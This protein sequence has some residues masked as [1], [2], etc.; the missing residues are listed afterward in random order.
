MNSKFCIDLKEYFNQ[1]TFHVLEKVA[2]CAINS[3]FK[4]YLV[5]GIVRDILLKRPSLDIDILIEGDAL[6]F[7]EFLKNNCTNI[8]VL[9][10]QEDLHT[11]KVIFDN[12]T[13]IDFASTRTEIYPQKGFLPVIEEIGVPIEEDCKRRDFTVNTLL[14]ALHDLHNAQI[15]DLTG[16]LSDLRE[17]TLRILHDKS[18]IDDPSRILRYLKFAVRFGFSADKHTESLLNEYLNNPNEQFP[19][20][21]LKSEFIQTFNLNIPKAAKLFVEQKMYKLFADKLNC[22]GDFAHLSEL[23]SKHIPNSEYI[24]LVWFI[25][26]F[27]AEDLPEMNF[28]TKEKNIISGVQQLFESTSDMVLYKLIPKLDTESVVAYSFIS[29]SE[30]IFAALEKLK[31]VNVFI[32]GDDLIKLGFEPSAEFKTILE[33]V[34]AEKLSHNLITKEDELEFVQNSFRHAIQKNN[35]PKG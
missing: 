21:R 30:K 14:I 9:K 10:I 7:V 27:G 5:G 1:E 29:G 13:E 31:K 15:T 16:G 19:L 25:S 34:L 32:T 26:V 28:D 8:E 18:F 3:G 11:A 23:V 24:W 35:A 6:D 22:K 20:S 4:V 17:K 12:K 33:K 2:D